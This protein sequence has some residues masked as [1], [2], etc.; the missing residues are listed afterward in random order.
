MSEV[1]HQEIEQILK[2]DPFTL[3]GLQ[4][5]FNLDSNDLNTKFR[6]LQKQ[7]HPDSWVNSRL[8]A[9]IIMASAHINAAYST[10]KNPLT[11]AMALLKLN[12][13]EVNLNNNGNLDQDFLFEQIEIREQI[14]E[15]QNSIEKLEHLEHM[16][17][18]KQEQIIQ[19]LTTLF[20]QHNFVQALKLTQHLAFYHKLLEVVSNTISKLW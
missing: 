13:I 12:G 5:Q 19:E 3:F 11:R 7:Y 4:Q 9:L 18:R 15:S 16:L 1:E 6:S 17:K 14:A 2:D 20:N 8:S 10:L